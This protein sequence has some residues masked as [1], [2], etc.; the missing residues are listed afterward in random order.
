MDEYASLLCYNIIDEERSFM[1]LLTTGAN[2]I[3][4]FSSLLTLRAKKI[5]RMSL[6]RLSQPSLMFEVTRVTTFQVLGHS[7]KH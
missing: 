2:F 1:T 7:L 3:K 5:D 4:H 6:G